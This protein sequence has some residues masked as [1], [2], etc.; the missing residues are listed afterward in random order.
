MASSGK[1]TAAELQGYY[2]SG[3]TKALSDYYNKLP[4]LVVLPDGRDNSVTWTPHSKEMRVGTPS[5]TPESGEL[6][7]EH[8]DSVPQ[9]PSGSIVVPVDCNRE[10]NWTARV[11]RATGSA[12]QLDSKS[13]SR[14][15]AQFIKTARGFSLV[16]LNSLN[17]TYVDGIKLIPELHYAIQPGREIRFGLDVKAIF[18]DIRGLAD[19]CKVV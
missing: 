16:D 13:I 19:I 10:N 12:I 14:Y 1:K 11:G 6:D 8:S 3:G 5:S 18:T 4:V 7:L 2:E 15:H 17:G 9:L